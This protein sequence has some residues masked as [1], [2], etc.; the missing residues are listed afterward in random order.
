MRVVKSDNILLA[1]WGVA[2]LVAWVAYHW[3]T[4]HP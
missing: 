4:L 2:A 3:V 1:V